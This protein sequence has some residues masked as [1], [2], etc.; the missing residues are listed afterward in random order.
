MPAL[1]VSDRDLA[2]DDDKARTFMDSFF[3]T[4]APAQEEPSICVLPGMLR[5]TNHGIRNLS[6]SH[7]RRELHSARRE[8]PPDTGLETPLDAPW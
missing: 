2:D 5:A 8:G 4:M 6:I 3:P 1:K 7:S